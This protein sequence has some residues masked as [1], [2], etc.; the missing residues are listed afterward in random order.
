MNREKYKLHSPADSE[1]NFVK[2]SQCDSLAKL[3]ERDLQELTAE[4]ESYSLSMRKSL[5]LDND[6][7]FG[8]EIEFEKAEFQKVR[9]GISE[10]RL[11][12]YSRVLQGDITFLNVHGDWEVQIDDTMFWRLEDDST[13]LSFIGDKK[14]GGEIVSPV[15]SDTES[16]W[17]ELSDICFMLQ[18]L[19]AVAENSSGG[20]I[21]FGSQILENNPRNWINMLMLWTVYEKIIFRFCYGDKLGPRKWLGAYAEPIADKLHRRL[22]ELRNTEGIKPL[23]HN[24][25]DKKTQALSFENVKLDDSVYLNTLEAR[26]PNSSINPIVWQNN[27]NMLAKLFL[28]CGSERFD[29]DFAQRKV[30]EYTRGKTL[31]SYSE[32]FLHEAL[33]FCDLIFTNNLDKIYFLKQYLKSFGYPKEPSDNMKLVKL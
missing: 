4:L 16:A 20:H 26:F 1:F 28:Y 13:V 24:L 19:N 14:C 6:I 15:L 33:E 25:P 29:E 2:F 9:E 11:P 27:I 32:I 17:Q 10:L 18:G 22:P 21:H 23:L 7:I 30:S 31:D 12:E 3:S 8:I 5:G